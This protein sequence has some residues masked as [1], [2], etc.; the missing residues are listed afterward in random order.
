V[1]GLSIVA[2]P[3]VPYPGG[4]FTYDYDSFDA[5]EVWNGR[6]HGPDPWQADNEAALAQWH[7]LLAASVDTGHWL[8]AVANSDAHRAGQ[9]RSPHNVVRAEALTVEGVLAGLRAGH[10]W[11]AESAGIDLL[12]TAE[13]TELDRQD[14]DSPVG[15][16]RSA[17]F[18]ERLVTGGA[19]VRVTVAVLGVPSGLVRLLTNHGL[20]HREFLPARGDGTL[21]W[22]PPAANPTYVC[23]EVR[24]PD[25]RPAALS[26]PIFLSENGE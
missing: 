25:G 21:H 18:G 9:L 5:I 26:N 15:A 6:W 1:G 3:Y 2:H 20:V 14:D 23:I 11:L 24:H 10:S 4:A 13:V 22:T 12:A 8:P 16:A 19:P 7:T 17:T